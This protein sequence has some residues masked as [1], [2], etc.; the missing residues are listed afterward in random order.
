[1]KKIKLNVILN[2]SDDYEVGNC[3]NCPI[4]SK[5][6]YEPFPGYYTEKTNCKLGYKPINCPV[7]EEKL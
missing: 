4:A 1:M 7:E 5:S 3:N 6:S 2:A